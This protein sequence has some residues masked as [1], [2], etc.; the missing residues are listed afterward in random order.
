MIKQHKFS[1]IVDETKFQV[2]LGYI[3]HQSET[4]AKVA[5]GRALA[6]DTLTIFAQSAKEHV[7]LD[8][9]VRRYG[10]ISSFSH[11][12]TLY[13]SS[14]FE[15]YGRRIKFLGLREPDISRPWVGYGDYPVNDYNDICAANY[16]DVYEIT[17]GLGQHLL[18][19]RRAEFDVLGY[20]VR[21]E[22]H[23]DRRNQ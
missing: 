18:E 10:P 1:P 15:I 20:I 5:L 12:P 19:I 7:F 4:L 23:D 21:E 17:S 22:D 3:A 6:V 8:R 2:A 16:P 14:D 13:I 11:G 9:V